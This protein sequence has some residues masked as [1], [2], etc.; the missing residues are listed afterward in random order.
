MMECSIRTSQSLKILIIFISDKDMSHNDSVIGDL[1]SNNGT[2]TNNQTLCSWRTE[3]SSEDVIKMS[4]WLNILVICG[5]LISICC[6]AVALRIML[7]CRKLPQSIRHFSVNF[8]ISF[9]TIGVSILIH[10]VAMLVF[11]QNTRYYQLIFVAR[12]FF[13][14]MFLSV[15]WCSMCAVIV[16]R[17]IAIV[18]PYHYVTLVKNTTLYITISFIWIFN[19]IVS[20]AIV[21]VSWLKFCGQ[22][23]CISSF[24][25]YAISRPF[26]SFVSCILCISFAITIVLYSKILLSIRHHKREIGALNVINTAGND[27]QNASTSTPHASTSTPRAS[28]KTILIIIFSFI[29]L[30]SPY[31]F[32]TICFQLIQDL[33]QMKWR[34]ITHIIFY[35]CHELNTFVT[36]FLYV[37]RFPECRMNFY[38]MFAKTNN[39]CREKAESLRIEVFNIVTFERNNR[40]MILES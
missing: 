34:T 28:T 14:S 1:C 6:N 33:Q 38:Y 29:V 24:E 2:L 37:W 8:L 4:Y 12:M 9:L 3:P 18:F 22:Y 17:F 40:T 15:L 20:I 7:R 16:E 32:A 36:L 19:T 26:I 27:T 21:I 31:L 10:N 11:G 35:I 5:L 13:F 39:K 30:Q 23:D 25:G